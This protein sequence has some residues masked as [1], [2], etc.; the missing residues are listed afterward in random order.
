MNKVVDSMILFKMHNLLF[1]WEIVLFAC[2]EEKI[3]LFFFIFAV[4]VTFGKKNWPKESAKLV[5]GSGIGLEKRQNN[6]N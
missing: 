2:S 4:K 1:H 6:Q 5:K 3:H